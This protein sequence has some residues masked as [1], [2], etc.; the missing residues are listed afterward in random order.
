MHPHQSSD[1]PS[2]FVIL[3]EETSFK[4]EV[5]L[6][7]SVEDLKDFFKKSYDFKTYQLVKCLQFLLPYSHL[8][9]FREH[10]TQS[11]KVAEQANSQVGCSSSDRWANPF[12]H[13][14]RPLGSRCVLGCRKRQMGLHRGC[15]QGAFRPVWKTLRS[16]EERRR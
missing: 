15:P 2:S 3:V 8:F 13:C 16:S 4:R 12:A 9:F 1:F 11:R 10:R 7:S 5:T 14:L 6:F